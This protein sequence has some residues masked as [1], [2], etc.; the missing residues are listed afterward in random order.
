MSRFT[1]AIAGIFK[2]IRS[3]LLRDGVNIGGTANYP[4]VEIHSIVE[5]TPLTKDN[6]LRQITATIECVSAEKVADI[7]QLTEDNIDLL[8]ADSALSLTGFDIVG[9]VPGQIR[10]FDEQEALDSTTV[11]Y[12]M[13]QDVTITVE[14]QNTES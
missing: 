7:V 2:A 10:M 9:I 5:D 12:R 14:K 4:R 11:I 13:L 6:S 1:S 8:F 3:A